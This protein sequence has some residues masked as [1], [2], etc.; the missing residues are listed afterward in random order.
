[1][2]PTL[3]SPS[4]ALQWGSDIIESDNTVCWHF[5]DIIAADANHDDSDENNNIK[6]DSVIEMIRVNLQINNYR[7]T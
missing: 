1:M 2:S 7:M 5:V 6:T 4:E 3:Y